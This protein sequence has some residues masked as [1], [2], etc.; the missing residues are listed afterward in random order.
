MT[1]AGLVKRV[2]P[3]LA[4]VAT[5]VTVLAQGLMPGPTAATDVAASKG[6]SAFR[7]S[8]GP[9]DLTVM[10]LQSTDQLAETRLGRPIP[11]YGLSSNTIR[12]F[13]QGQDATTLLEKSE[14]FFYPVQLGP[15]VVGSVIVANSDTGWKPAELGGI[16]LAQAVMELLDQSTRLTGIPIEQYCIVEV[17]T[18]NLYFIAHRS[19]GKLLLQPLFDVPKL[20]L[21]AGIEV[22][23]E[24]ILGLLKSLTRESFNAPS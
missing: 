11:I 6:L 3:I 10:G 20:K 23:A 1:V 5:E 13:R 14:E 18:L 22:S 12:G 2:I 21:R 24:K 17:V 7:N 16:K 4:M 8:T 15:L 19:D 9:E